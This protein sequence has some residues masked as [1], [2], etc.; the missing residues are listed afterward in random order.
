MSLTMT[1]LPTAIER[2]LKLAGYEVATYPSAQQL[3]TAC[4]TRRARLHSARCADTRPQRSRIA[5]ASQK[6][7]SALPIVFLTGHADTPTTVQTIK[8]GAED[9]LTKPVESAQLLVPSNGRW[10]GTPPRVVN[11]TSSAKCRHWWAR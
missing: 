3:L 7:G 1:I 11:D 5:R 2:R 6:L 4:R 9:F 10:H 8:A